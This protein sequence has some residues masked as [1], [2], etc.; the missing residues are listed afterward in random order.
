MPMLEAAGSTVATFAQ[1]PDLL[2]EVFVPETQSA[3]PEF[4]RHDPASALYYGDAQ[5]DH[6][7][8]FGVVAV[9]PAQPDRPVARAFS[10]PFAFHDGTRGARNCRTAAGVR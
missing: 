2:D 6:Y 10:V 3:V 5:L 9:D 7:R 1:R 8:E 4:M